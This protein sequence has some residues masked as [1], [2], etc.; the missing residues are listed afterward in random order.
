MRYIF[1]DRISHNGAIKKLY[2]IRN[3]EETLNIYRKHDWTTGQ[4]DKLSAEVRGKSVNKMC[5]MCIILIN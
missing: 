2:I 1:S 4:L 3:A 5:F